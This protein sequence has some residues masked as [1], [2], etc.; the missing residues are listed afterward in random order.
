L[1]QFRYRERV[2]WLQLRFTVVMLEPFERLVALERECFVWLS[3]LNLLFSGISALADFQFKGNY[4]SQFIQFFRTYFPSFSSFSPIVNHPKKG[5][6]TH[7]GPIEKH[8]YNYFRSGLAH[9]FVIW[10][11]GLL[12]VED[13]APAFVFEANE[14][15]GVAPRT[16]VAEYRTAVNSFF[17]ALAAQEE[18]SAAARLFTSRFQERFLLK[19]GGI[20]PRRIG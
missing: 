10:W 12:H 8:F 3:A 1:E 7:A 14:G 4:E 6:R 19:T 13:G 5:P 20:M 17:S 9:H 2:E 11:G 16:L 15:I 18:N